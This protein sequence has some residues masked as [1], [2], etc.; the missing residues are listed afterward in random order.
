MLS[1]IKIRRRFCFF[2]QLLW[3]SL[4]ILTPLF[5]AVS[6]KTVS[7]LFKK[8]NADD[9][10]EGNSDVFVNSVLLPF[11]DKELQHSFDGYF[12]IKPRAERG[13]GCIKGGG[14]CL[15]GVREDRGAP[16]V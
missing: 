12:F 10:E 3:E 11:T 4:V 13:T 8:W 7:T 6:W 16:F 1:F 2:F 9:A 5:K 15:S 14:V